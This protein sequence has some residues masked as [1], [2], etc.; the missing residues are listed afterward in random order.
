MT[1]YEQLLNFVKTYTK[2][3]CNIYIQERQKQGSGIIFIYYAE[4]TKDVK[5]V[6]IAEE[7][8]TELHIYKE[9][10]NR[11]AANA[12]E[13]IIYFFVNNEEQSSFVEL[14]IRDYI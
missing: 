4:E 5:V 12:S 3:L 10:N 2:Q 9:Y 13:N 7:H 1:I 11:R 6:Y 14:D 8:M